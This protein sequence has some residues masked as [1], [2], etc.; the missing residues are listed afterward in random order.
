M[1][2]SVKVSRPKSVDFISDFLGL[3]DYKNEWNKKDKKRT[4]VARNENKQTASDIKMQTKSFKIDVTIVLSS[5]NY[6]H[7]LEWS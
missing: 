5:F 1:W 4:R 3:R 7:L 2:P 6:G